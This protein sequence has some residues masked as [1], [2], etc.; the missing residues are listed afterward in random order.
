MLKLALRNS[1]RV[2]SRREVGDGGV[3]DAV[4]GEG[5]DEEEPERREWRG[6]VLA[7]RRHAGL[8]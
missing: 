1:A 4:G 3:G 2:K 5:E 6:V 8:S 7:W